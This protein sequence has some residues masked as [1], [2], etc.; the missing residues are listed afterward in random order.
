MI[1]RHRP[2]GASSALC[3]AE[4]YELIISL[5]KQLLLVPFSRRYR[6]VSGIHPLPSVRRGPMYRGENRL[7]PV[8][9]CANVG[10]QETPVQDAPPRNERVVPGGARSPHALCLSDLV[11]EVLSRAENCCTR[12]VFLIE[13]ALCRKARLCL[14]HARY[15]SGHEKRRCPLLSLGRETPI[16]TQSTSGRPSAISNNDLS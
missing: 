6:R 12:L 7:A 3:S 9:P 16:Q 14:P 13:E 1:S 15:P 2:E 8:C 11:A 10:L 5:M 4:R